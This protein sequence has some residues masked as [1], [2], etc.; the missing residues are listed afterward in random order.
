MGSKA[1]EDLQWKE[2]KIR[3]DEMLSRLKAEIKEVRAI[4]KDLTRQFI[5][6]GTT[7]NHLKAKQRQ[8][9]WTDD[10]DGGV[11][12]VFAVEV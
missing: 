8:L 7:I 5:T 6:L 2:Q 11:E 4:D 12:Q 10:E 9:S 3:M 1:K